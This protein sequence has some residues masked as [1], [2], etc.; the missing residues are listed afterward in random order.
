MREY[1]SNHPILWG[2]EVEIY[3]D[4]ALVYTMSRPPQWQVNR[5][6]D[7][8]MPLYKNVAG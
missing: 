2:P 8:N 6:I 3:H 7:L 4:D 1:V 5:F